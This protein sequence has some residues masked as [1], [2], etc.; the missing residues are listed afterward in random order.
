METKCEVLIWGGRERNIVKSLQGLNPG[1]VALRFSIETPSPDAIKL[2]EK[3]QKGGI[4]VAQYQRDG[5]DIAEVYFS[6][7]IDGIPKPNRVPIKAKFS[8][9]YI[10]KLLGLIFSGAKKLSSTGEG[11]AYNLPGEDYVD[12]RSG[13]GVDLTKIFVPD[14]DLNVHIGERRKIIE[15]YAKR[16]RIGHSLPLYQEYAATP[17]SF[18]RVRL[19]EQ[20]RSNIRGMLKERM[21]S[22]EDFLQQ[23]LQPESID[24]GM[25][26]KHYHELVRSAEV[27]TGELIS[28]QK[29]SKGNKQENE[30][31]NNYE[32]LQFKLV[33]Q[34]RILQIVL[35]ALGKGKESAIGQP[36]DDSILLDNSHIDAIAAL[37]EMDKIMSDGLNYH[38]I[39]KN[40]SSTA[41]K[42][43]S[44][45][46]VDSKLKKALNKYKNRS[47]ADF[48]IT[49]STVYKAI[50]A[51]N[52]LIQNEG[53]TNEVIMSEGAKRSQSLFSRLINAVKGLYQ[54]VN[55]SIKSISGKP[56]TFVSSAFEPPSLPT[57]QGQKGE[58]SNAPPRQKTHRPK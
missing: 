35:F 44:Q 38:S 15:Q 50:S 47:Y 13:R 30:L 9:N 51:S 4:P 48:L 18:Y 1:H 2:V 58:S 12:E 52:S 42:V 17:N 26:I 34:M 24:A 41:L 45:S 8:I 56:D 36:P 16:N 19:T 53:L 11:V 6:F 5:K 3:L 49:P 22:D 39:S 46:V 20:I 10:I 27:V 14:F 31:I 25:Y 55:K 40:C 21:I 54:R 29:N 57:P 28:M 32:L 33:N 23:L 37:Q 7:G 43:L